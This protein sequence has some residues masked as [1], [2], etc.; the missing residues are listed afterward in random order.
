MKAKNVLLFAMCCLLVIAQ[1]IAVKTYTT[2][3]ADSAVRECQN[4]DQLEPVYQ[5]DASSC[6]DYCLANHADACEWNSGTGDCYVEFGTDCAV[7]GTFEGWYA[8][9]FALGSMEAD[10]AVRQCQDFDQFEPV[11]EGDAASCRDYC[12]GNHADACEWN[13][14]TGDCYAEFGTGCAVE[15]GYSG[16]YSAVKQ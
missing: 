10:S 1:G 11:Y 5:G 4:Y 3:T 15:G 16:W 14:G 2:M 12:A 8:E 9:V 6:G 13:S 7:E